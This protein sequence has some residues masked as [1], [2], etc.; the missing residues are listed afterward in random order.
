MWW[1][2][3]LLDEPVWIARPVRAA[4]GLTAHGH[5]VTS[6]TATL[7]PPIGLTAHGHAVTSGSATLG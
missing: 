1:H 2:A 7:G 5:A 3:Y 4:V 6:G